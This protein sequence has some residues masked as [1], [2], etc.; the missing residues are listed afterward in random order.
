MDYLIH[1]RDQLGLESLVTFAGSVT[2]EELD[3]YYRRCDAIIYL[4]LDETFGLPFAEAAARSKPS[5]G[6]DHGGPA[7]FIEPGRT[8]LLVDAL[9]PDAVAST[10]VEL[11]SDPIR[12][13]EMGSAA[14]K[15][16]E[17]EYTIDAMVDRY[18]HWVDSSVASRD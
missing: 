16:V 6:P 4:T 9:D 13:R 10:I 8:G 14:R 5:I 7:E 11:L 1:V 12:M 3:L 2:D 15:K 18:L 17:T